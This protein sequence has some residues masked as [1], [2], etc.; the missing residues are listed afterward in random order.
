MG[1][2]WGGGNCGPL[3]CGVVWDLC[4]LCMQLY[5]SDHDLGLHV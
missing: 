3:K 1:V 4:G 2:N 5:I